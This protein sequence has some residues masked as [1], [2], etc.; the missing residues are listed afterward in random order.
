MKQE[1]YL[2]NHQFTI[3]YHLVLITFYKSNSIAFSREG[4]TIDGVWM[5]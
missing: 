5:G 4:V 2:P 1:L 3:R